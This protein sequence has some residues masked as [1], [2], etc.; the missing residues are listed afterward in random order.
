MEASAVLSNLSGP[1]SLLAR[2]DLEILLSPRDTA[3]L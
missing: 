3:L 1:S 2:K